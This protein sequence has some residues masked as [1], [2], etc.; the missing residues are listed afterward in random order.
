M[1]FRLSLIIKL[2]LATSLILIG[3]MSLLDY[4]NIKNFRKATIE[5]AISNADQLT[6][7]INQSTYDAMMKNDK[8]SLY[9]MIGRIAQSPNI[10]NIRLIDRDGKVVFCSDNQ[11]VGS[12]IDR[13]K[14]DTCGL[15]HKSGSPALHSAYMKSSRLHQNKTGS[16]VLGFTKAI[17]N[18]PECSTGPCHFHSKTDNVLG[19]LDIHISLENLRQKSDYYRLQFVV[20]TCMLLILIGLLINLLTQ[21]LVNRPVQRLVQHTAQ[22]AAG[23]LTAR[24]PVKS[25]D[26]LGDLATAFNHMTEN[27]AKAQEELKHWADSLE[28]K[29]EERSL[30]IKQMETQLHRSEKLASLGNL[31]AGIAHEI[32]NPLSGILLYASIVYKDKRLE[33]ALKPD[34][35]LVVSECRRCANIVKQLLGFSREAVPQKVAVSINSLLEKVTS[36]LKPQPSFLNIEIQKNYDL[37]FE[38]IFVDENQMQ[39]VFVNLLIN[40]SHAMSSWGLIQITTSRSA[41]NLY[42]CAEISDNGC[43][44]QPEILENIFDPFFTTKSEGTGLGLSISYGF[45]QNNEGK[46]EVLSEVGVGTTFIIQLPLNSGAKSQIA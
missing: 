25:H 13:K 36:L 4:I 33:P 15:C 43:G 11:E 34:L 44:I 17:Y 5:Y 26:E 37:N 31:V 23:D 45:I 10:E 42:A 27:L 12:F 9:Q 14:D 1:H 41:D 21:R 22:V 3:F 6:E 32:N 19:V 29:V 16:E 30:E 18:K 39:Q 40:A 8:T 35:E 24:I 28:Q 7:I 38:D 2:T 20:M 46:I